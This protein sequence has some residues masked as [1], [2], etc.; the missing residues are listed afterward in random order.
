MINRDGSNFVTIQE[1]VPILWR[2]VFSALRNESLNLR[3]RRRRRRPHLYDGIG[4]RDYLVVINPRLLANVELEVKMPLVSDIASSLIC[5][6]S[7][8]QRSCRL[9]INGSEVA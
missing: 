6:L 5:E 9:T 3:T 1:L 8:L 2:N 4:C 7:R